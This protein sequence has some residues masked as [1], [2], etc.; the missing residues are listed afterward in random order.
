[1][2]KITILILIL[3]LFF[4]PLSYADIFKS[5]YLTAYWPLDEES[6]TRY[7]KQMHKDMTEHGTV[8]AIDGVKNKA[9]VFDSGMPR[10]FL[11]TSDSIYLTPTSSVAISLWV[12]FDNVFSGDKYVIGRDAAYGILYDPETKR[13]KAW[14]YESDGNDI[15]VE[16][17]INGIAGTWHH[18]VFIADQGT[19][20]LYLDN[21]FVASKP[22]DN[23]ISKGNK[24]TALG[25][26][27]NRDQDYLKGKI[28]EVGFWNNP[29]FNSIVEMNQF[30]DALYNNDQGVAYE[31]IIPGSVDVLELVKIWI[32]NGIDPMYEVFNALNS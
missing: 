18:I 5:E 32:N 24:I 28:D 29:Q 8:P 30:V 16:Y 20:R 31:D 7:D 22:Y 14:F 2:K 13:L 15:D 27:P 23:T 25:R 21:N 1:M 12:F 17:Y 10:R 26:I 19:A 6:G 3:S 9:A 11:Y 4:I